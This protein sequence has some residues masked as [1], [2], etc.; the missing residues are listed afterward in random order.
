M[1]WGVIGFAAG[2]FMLQ[3]Q[4]RLWPWPWLLLL[5]V[6][7]FT[8]HFFPILL[9]K[10]IPSNKRV[11]QFHWFYS[12]HLVAQRSWV[13]HARHVLVGIMLGWVWASIM[14]HVSLSESLA[15]AVEDR[16]LVVTG[17]VSGLPTVSAF[18]QRFHF[19]IE[20]VEGAQPSAVPKKVM[21]SWNV[22]GVNINN[23]VRS[24]ER[25]R[26]NV[27][28]RQPHG[29][30]N[31]YGFDVEAW[32]LQQG[33]RA[34]G[35]VKSDR[36]L[37]IKN[38]RITEFVVSVNSCIGRTRGWLRERILGAL[39]QQPYAAVMV[40][41]VIG[42][43]N[44]ITQADWTIFAR[45]GIS[46]LISISG[47]HITMIAAVVAKLL[48]FL[49]R[50]SFFTSVQLPLWLPA[51]KIAA[52]AGAMS[53][54]VYVA[55]AG[56]G[57]PSQRTLI[58]VVVI[59]LAM[60]F[61]RV[62]RPSLILAIALLVVLV[63]DPWAVV[64]PGF[65]LS[66]GAVALLFY[67]GLGK[68][69]SLTEQPDF[70]A[71]V[72]KGIRF[73]C[74]QRLQYYRGQL[75]STLVEAARIQ[76]VLT[77]GLVPITLLLFSQMSVVS[78]LA[79]AIAI[80]VISFIVTPC[81]LLGAIMPF[82]LNYWLLQVGHECM[83][84]LVSIMEWLSSM[85]WAVWSAPHPALLPFLCAVLGTLW[86]LAPPGWPLRWT[87]LIAWLPLCLQ[88]S[89]APSEGH[90]RATAL[91]IGQGTAVLIET[92]RHRLLYD[93]GPVYSGQ[94]NG[95]NR[96]IIPYLKARGIQR[97]DG[98]VIS[99][100]DNDHSGGALSLI[101]EV[102]INWL[103]TSMTPDHPIVQALQRRSGASG[104][105]PCVAG[106]SWEWDGVQFD[107]L[108]PTASYYENSKWKPN[109]KSCTLKI[110]HRAK[111]DAVHSLLLTGDIGAQ[112]EKQLLH[113]IEPEQQRATVLLVP[114]HGSG[115]SS[116]EAFLHAVQPELALFQFGYRNRYHHPKPNVWQRYADLG[117]RRLRNDVG[118]AITLH[119]G[120][121][122]HFEEYRQTHA[123]YW[124]VPLQIDRY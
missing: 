1:R 89:S 120:A 29:A 30:A 25:W 114:H 82:P 42:E 46:H 110:S 116:T 100:S 11:A 44:G 122:V 108:H 35:T 91:D 98:L 54:L 34:T 74:Q 124:Y 4:P 53:A 5:T 88:S 37:S 93:T 62:M 72:G 76:C 102:P 31:P 111:G 39:G 19:K 32:L 65:W 67:S 85:A 79:N 2:I 92:A 56:F 73:R 20:H 103:V 23:M 104:Y 26:L 6:L 12:V 84:Q 52:L 55:L 68:T 86:C 10:I 113:T 64:W 112:Q 36:R 63:F 94:A 60:W 123:R 38:Q 115:T 47:L 33:I 78:P 99:H 117:I 40:A 90:F 8:V 118:G 16:D 121:T 49:W 58:M 48:Y 66:F 106:Q 14:A 43:Q 61:D 27:R 15:P 97:L 51:Q 3:H 28:L 119:F 81:A 83:Q 109:A 21:L 41:L 13:S 22:P 69:L 18:G 80:P 75:W 105:A 7:G 87:G 95:G 59:A 77:L 50:H 101:N 71:A 96:V 24:G 70:S 17:I 45:T 107:M 9:H 57:V